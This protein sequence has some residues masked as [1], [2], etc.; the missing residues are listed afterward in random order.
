[1]TEL[2]YLTSAS[3][4]KER[5]RAILADSQFAT[6]VAVE[7]GEVCG[8]IGLF[9]HHSYEHNDFSGRVLALVVAERFRRCGIARDLISKAERYFLD[10]KIRRVVITAR[11]S[12]STAHRFYEAMGYTETGIRFGKELRLE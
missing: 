9:A 5:L 4:M 3:E 12:R 2:G 7:D 10:R 1:M 8:M 11:L 6:F